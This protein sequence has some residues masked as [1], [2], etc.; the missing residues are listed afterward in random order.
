MHK[1]CDLIGKKVIRPD[2]AS[3][4]GTL[5]N[6]LLN[7]DFT[8]IKFW[9]LF[10]DSD[11]TL[12]VDARH[13]DCICDVVM[14]KQKVVP[15]KK[16]NLSSTL[17][18]CPINLPVYQID[19]KFLGIVDDVLLDNQTVMA[20]CIKDYSFTPNK[21]IKKSTEMLIVSCENNTED[22]K[23]S[24]NVPFGFTK[25]T[26]T[27]QIKPYPD[28]TIIDDKT[29]AQFPTIPYP[30]QQENTNLKVD[31]FSFLLGKKVTRS[32]LD[33]QKN[34]LAYAGQT[35]DKNLLLIMKQHNLLVTLALNAK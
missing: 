18:A 3:E 5:V 7:S 26:V 25:N 16:D 6:A 27:A 22:I 15:T 32:L 35:V 14:L 34:T 11:E 28:I 4:I 1:L 24:S 29:M 33:K 31:S 13:V 8:K 19:G 23:T 21:I 9:E 10:N 30:I 17:C 2:N 20:I 12:Y